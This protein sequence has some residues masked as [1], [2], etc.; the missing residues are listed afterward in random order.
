VKFTVVRLPTGLQVSSHRPNNIAKEGIV[1][2][3]IRM[4]IPK[5]GVLH[6]GFERVENIGG[7]YEKKSVD[8]IR[9]PKMRFASHPFL[10]RAREGDNVFAVAFKLEATPVGFVLLPP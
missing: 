5:G 2:I 10:D 8:G 1:L 6:E 9:I 4:G 3:Y 7:G